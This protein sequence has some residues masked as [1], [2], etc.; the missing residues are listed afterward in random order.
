MTK[1][2]TGITAELQ[3]RVRE[4][5]VEWGCRNWARQ[6]NELV[7]TNTTDPAYRLPIEAGAYLIT[8]L[9]EVKYRITLAKEASK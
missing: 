1:D 7:V 9:E 8:I 4:L 3:A 5:V 2:A 6:D